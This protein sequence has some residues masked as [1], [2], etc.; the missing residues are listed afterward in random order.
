MHVSKAFTDEDQIAPG[1]WIP[2]SPHVTQQGCVG[3]HPLCLT[4]KPRADTYSS[5]PLPSL[6]HCHCTEAAVATRLS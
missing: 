6:L 2:G 5:F 1:K 4:V 3:N